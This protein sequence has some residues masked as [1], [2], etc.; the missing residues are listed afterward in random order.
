MIVELTDLRGVSRLINHAAF[1]K[2]SAET[3]LSSYIRQL[4]K[5]VHFETIK[6]NQ[7][8]KTLHGLI[9]YG[10]NLLAQN[11]RSE[12]VYKSTLLNDFILTNYSLDDTIILNEFRINDSIADVVLV[13]GT[14]KVF[15]IKTELDT[16]ERFKSQVIDY[17]KAFSEVY[18]VTHFSVYEKYLKLI[19]KRVGVIIYTENNTLQEIREAEKVVEYLDIPTMMASLRKPEYLALVRTLVGFVP[20]ATPVFLYQECL[21]ILLQ[22][23]PK[24]V[25][26]AYHKILKKRISEAKNID[27][28]EKVFSN[29]LNYSYYNQ[30]INKKSYITLQ[31]NLNKKV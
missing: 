14:N 21:S 25:Q 1:K 2:L 26:Y 15:E 30:K 10:Y 11:Y 19:D 6:D 31:N 18:L 9:D 16:L 23:T 22:F 29:S 17:Y 13:N 24:E 7:K 27:I 3:N 20:E 4:K 5:H 28:N 8:P 12:Y